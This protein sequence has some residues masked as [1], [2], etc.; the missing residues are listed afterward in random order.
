MTCNVKT[1]WHIIFD[2]HRVPLSIK[3]A[4]E[5][6]RRKKRIHTIHITTFNPSTLF[7]IQY[8]WNLSFNKFIEQDVGYRIYNTRRTVTSVP[9]PILQTATSACSILLFTCLF[10]ASM[11]TIVFTCITKL[12]SITTL[13][14]HAVF[15]VTYFSITMLWTRFITYIS[16]ETGWTIHAVSSISVTDFFHTSQRTGRMTRHAP[17]S[18]ITPVCTISVAFITGRVNT[19]WRAHLNKKKSANSEMLFDINSFI[20]SVKIKL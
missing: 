17:V 8:K 1:L 14:T 5:R 2:T 13:Y 19:M 20:F 9:S 3:F 18:R 6:T 7:C 4:E 11:T 12:S 15:L 16:P 10:Y